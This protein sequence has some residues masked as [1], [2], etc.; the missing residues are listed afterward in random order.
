M[1]D[2][3]TIL[4][5]TIE[6]EVRN[7]YKAA[8]ALKGKSLRDWA[9]EAMREKLERDLAAGGGLQDALRLADALHSRIAAGAARKMDAAKDIRTLREKRLKALGP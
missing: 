4:Y 1:A 6:P 9:L 8:A 7:Q 2:K 5:F 3:R